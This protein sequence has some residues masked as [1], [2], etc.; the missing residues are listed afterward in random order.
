MKMNLE[1]FYSIGCK[2]SIEDIADALKKTYGL[3]IPYYSE[4]EPPETAYNRKRMQYDA[5]ILLD[6]MIPKKGENLM[7]LIIDKDLYCQNMN[8]I[9]GYALPG[10]GA[11]LSTFRLDSR[12][13]IQKE[14]IHEIGHVLGLGH[15]HNLCVMQFSNSVQEA[16]ES[17]LNSVRNAEIL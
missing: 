9:L 2:N 13:L 11:I 6:F 7:L 12:E 8:F 17:P 15:C 5:S 4:I 16:M 14:A 10:K 1:V 3:E